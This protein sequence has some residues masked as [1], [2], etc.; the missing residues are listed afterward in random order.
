[1]PAVVPAVPLGLRGVAF[2]NMSL[3]LCSDSG[4]RHTPQRVR[5][6]NCYAAYKTRLSGTRS[7]VLE[8]VK[9]GGFYSVVKAVVEAWHKVSAG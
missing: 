9:A 5:N 3:G 7:M 8:L 6:R 2:E 4:F 1:M